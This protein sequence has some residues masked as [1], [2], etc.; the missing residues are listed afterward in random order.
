M[1]VREGGIQQRVVGELDVGGFLVTGGVGLDLNGGIDHHHIAHHQFRR[2]VVEVDA[3]LGGV[4]RLLAI[5]RIVHLEADGAASRQVRSDVL[6][7]DAGLRADRIAADRP[8]PVHLRRAAVGRHIL[9][10]AG[11]DVVHGLTIPRDHCR[12][13]DPVAF[14]G[15][16]GREGPLIVDDAGG[17]HLEGRNIDDQVGLAQ[18][19]DRR[20]ALDGAEWIDPL[21]ARRAGLDPMDQGLDLIGR[22][23]LAVGEFSDV[24][25]G[26]VGRHPVGADH[27][28]DHR[29]KALDHL[30]VGH[31]ERPD[32]TLLV[33]GDAL[34]FEDRGDLLGIRNIGELRGLGALREVD[35]RAV[36]G[37]GGP[38][39]RLAGQ[40]RI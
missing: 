15:G 34:G 5:G 8:A 7:V 29:G 1:G 31:R 35:D 39:N 17:R 9:H 30:V 4:G 2:L 19:P 23:I 6:G 32:P 10:P 21:A 13:A 14:G 20:H 26:V 36:A 38:C 18:R 22:H 40:H 12:G 27:L 11:Q 37:H 3:D 33:T 24:R 16:V 28:A 25:I